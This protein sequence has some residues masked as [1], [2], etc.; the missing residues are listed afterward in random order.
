MFIPEHT[1]SG[2]LHVAFNECQDL[3]LGQA[4]PMWSHLA[5][6]AF[7]PRALVHRALAHRA[8]AHKALATT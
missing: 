7:A 5:H 8:L 1:I 2:L 6:T 4:R 3:L